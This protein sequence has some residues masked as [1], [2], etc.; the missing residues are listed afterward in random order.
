[1]W[2][3]FIFGGVNNSLNYIFYENLKIIIN[4]AINNFNLANTFGY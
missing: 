1:M 4:L 3:Y 2:E